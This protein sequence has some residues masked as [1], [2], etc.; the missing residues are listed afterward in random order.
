MASQQ[1]MPTEHYLD[2]LH[3]YIHAWLMHTGCSSSCSCNAYLALNRVPCRSVSLSLDAY[4]T[5]CCH[6]TCL[7]PCCH[8]TCLVTGKTRLHRLFLDLKDTLRGN[9]LTHQHHEATQQDNEKRAGTQSVTTSDASL[10]GRQMTRHMQ[11]CRQRCTRCPCQ[12]EQM[13]ITQNQAHNH[14]RP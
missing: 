5:G 11:H 13:N 9:C 6:W 14:L 10:K 3:P 1:M 7:L 8:G 2:R 12:S 4:N